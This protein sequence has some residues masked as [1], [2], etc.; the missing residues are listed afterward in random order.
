MGS[1]FCFQYSCCQKI[2]NKVS[3]QSSLKQDSKWPNK[4]DLHRSEANPSTHGLTMLW[5]PC[6]LPNWDP[7]SLFQ[8]FFG[9]GG[10]WKVL[11]VKECHKALEARAETSC[12]HFHLFCSMRIVNNDIIHNIET[13]LFVVLS[14]KFKLRFQRDRL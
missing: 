6:L 7:T 12:L 1:T 11:R 10:T 5:L 9:Q 8:T 13:K 14:K 3:E 4:T 2:A